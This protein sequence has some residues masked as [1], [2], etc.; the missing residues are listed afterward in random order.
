MGSSKARQ[1]IFVGSIALRGA[2]LLLDVLLLVLL[3]NV[4]A[5]AG[6]RPGPVMVWSL[7]ALY[8]AGMP[9]SPLQGTPGKWM[10]RIKLC[11]RQ[12]GRLSWH[13]SA[14]RAGAMLGWFALPLLFSREIV[15]GV[16]A[17]LARAVLLLLIAIPWAP[18]AFLPRGESLFDLLA[19]SLVVRLKAD[20]EGIAR[21]EPARKPG[22]LNVSGA[23]IV[24]LLPGIVASVAIPVQG[25]H[26][27]R[28]RVSRAISQARP[29]QRKIEEFYG[30]EKRWPSAQALGV[31]EWTPFDGGGYRL[32]P[33]G[34][35]LL[36]FSD[37]RDLKDHSVSLRP[38]PGSSRKEMVWRCSGDSGLKPQMLPAAC[39]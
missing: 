18:I 4:V 8:F 32:Q 15:T 22:I 31:A 5:I 24:C 27:Q 21:S 33:D 1:T 37:M 34:T 9:L 28:A 2:A 26:E 14:L 29:L 7:A 25:D 30:R 35:I 39:R 6:L 17:D 11:N 36:S 12:G 13:A 3:G 20:P 10:V 23:L 38:V 19:G 16:A